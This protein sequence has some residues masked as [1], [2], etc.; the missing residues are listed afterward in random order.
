MSIYRRGAMKQSDD[1]IVCR[2]FIHAFVKERLEGTIQELINFDFFL[3]VATAAM[4]VT[5][6]PLIATIPI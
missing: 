2:D 5:G 4:G 1:F 3:C 6:A